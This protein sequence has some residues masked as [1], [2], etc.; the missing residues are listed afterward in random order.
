MSKG[1]W[2]FFG[3]KYLSIFPLNKIVILVWSNTVKK[4]IE[5]NHENTTKRMITNNIVQFIVDAFIK[6]KFFCFISFE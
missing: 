2:F 1:T 5:R 6:K 4:V 3:K